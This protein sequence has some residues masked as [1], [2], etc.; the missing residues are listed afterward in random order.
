[1]F[2]L[3]DQDR[4][5]TTPY[6]TYLIILINIIV[7]LY[8]QS[9][10]K[11]GLED[12]VAQYAVSTQA[13][14]KGEKFYTLV[15][16]LFLHGGIGHIF[17]NMLF[18][19]IFGDN[20]EEAYGHF[21]FI[22]FYLVCGTLA[23][24]T[25]VFV[26]PSSTLPLIGASGAI[27]GLMGGYLVLFPRNKIDVLIIFGFFIRILTFPAVSILLFWILFQFIIGL[28][29]LGIPGAGGIAYFAHVGGFV[30][31]VIITLLL[32]PV[33]RLNTED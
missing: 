3:R 15:T 12:F 31:G 25:H 10:F 18:L 21:K 32:S 24:L 30:F 28:G 1:M 7:F 6:V 9:L 16:S 2:P 13:I 14:L 29:S 17:F 5:N 27:A 20:L 19:Q 22:I 11:S 23:S 4:T 8:M 33:L 26:N